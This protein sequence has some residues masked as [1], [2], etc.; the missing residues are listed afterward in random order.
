MS[1]TPA[2]TPV[3]PAPRPQ[4]NNAIFWILGIIGGGILVLILGA[5]ALASFIIHRV[6]VSQNADRVDIETP[7]GALKVSQDQPGATGLPVYP[8]AVLQ[9]SEGANFEITTNDT[10]AGFA[11]V[12]YKT[13]D[14]RETVKEWYAK[15]LGPSFTLESGKIASN[16]DMQGLPVDVKSDDV[17]FVSKNSS[18]GNARIVALG[19]SDGGTDIVLLR[20]GR[21]EP[22]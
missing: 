19:V 4:P 22:Q 11:V 21:Q 9:K 16:K 8:G 1:V 13:D 17:A 10:H 7:I 18:G 12:K 14:E 6:H 15:R 5:L 20:I 3:P 2:P